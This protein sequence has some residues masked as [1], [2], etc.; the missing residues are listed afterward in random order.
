MLHKIA[1][2]TLYLVSKWMSEVNFAIEIVTDI[3]HG[4]TQGFI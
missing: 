1:V 2:H 3:L 4:G